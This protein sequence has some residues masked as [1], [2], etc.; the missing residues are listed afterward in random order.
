MF[1]PLVSTAGLKTFAAGRASVPLTVPPTAYFQLNSS[2]PGPSQLQ[3]DALRDAAIGEILAQQRA[4]VYD[5]AAQIYSQEGLAA[6]SVVVPLLSNPASAVKPLFAPLGSTIARQLQSVAQLIEGRNQTQMRRQVFYVEDSTYDTHGNQAPL[7]AAL[8]RNLSRGIY[9]FLDAMTVLGL[10][11]KVT[12]FTLSE[13]GRT[14]K[15]AA[16]NGTDHGWGHY[17]FV[18]GGAVKGGD[19]YGKLPVQ[20]LNGPDDFGNS[21]RWIPT[22]SLE[23]YCATLTRW[24]GIADD[25]LP[26]I[27]PN[28]GAFANT[29]M[30]FLR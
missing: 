23:Q 17:G 7:H 8:L 18:A 15:P 10:A 3:F 6:S 22:T 11:D 5:I 26:Y 27:F 19:I 25:D 20:V 1:P 2:A 24:F 14:F 30:G 16:N 13:F 29:N 4:N 28:I 12:I 21:G 9:A